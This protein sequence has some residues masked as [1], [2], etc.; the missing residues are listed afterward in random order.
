MIRIAAGL[1]AGFALWGGLAGP[2]DARHA[3]DPFA[4]HVGIN[5]HIDFYTS[6]YGA[7]ASDPRPNAAAI[8]AIENALTYLGIS[9]VRDAIDNPFY[10]DIFAAMNRDIGVTFDFFIS[11]TKFEPNG[12]PSFNDKLGWMLKYPGIVDFVE[13]ANESDQSPQTYNGVTGTDMSFGPTLAEQKALDAAASKALGEGHV[14]QASFLNLW[15]ADRVV[16][17]LQNVPTL[18][19]WADYGNAHIYFATGHGARNPGA[20]FPPLNN[21][22]NWVPYRGYDV[23]FGQ[24][25]MMAHNADRLAPRAPVIASESG[26]TTASGYSD[27]VD[28]QSQ[29]K[30]TLTL[31]PDELNAG[32]ARIYLYELFDQAPDPS[33][34]TAELHYGLYNAARKAKPAASA[35]HNLMALIGDADI[36]PEPLDYRLKD[37]ADGMASRLFR[38]PDGTYVLAVW[39]DAKT[40]GPDAQPLAVRDAHVTL[41]LGKRAKKIAIY[42]PL[43]DA[44]PQETRR[45][46]E[47]LALDVPDHPILVFITP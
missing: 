45:A 30:Y 41:T 35:L 5:T 10:A 22:A 31:L 18:V 39:N 13:G 27:G 14:V 44:K 32:I 17:I 42:D 24:V 29:A 9:H 36:D 16:E 33:G 7:Y 47:R 4:D 21:D 43:E 15:N 34:A 46:V 6:S 2:A 8:A 28:P 19:N 37:M 12:T 11:P 40:C 23:A 25:A 1:V 38:K 26:Y 3:A 20:A